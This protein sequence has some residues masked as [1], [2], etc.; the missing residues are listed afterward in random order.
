MKDFA[1]V[2][3]GIGGTSI[4]AYLSVKGYDVILFE[5]ESYLGGCSSTFEHRGYLY[6]TGATT[7]AGY[8]DGHGVKN[9]LDGIGI[10]PEIIKTDPAMSVV[11]NGICIHRYKDLDHFL[12]EIQKLHPH[13]KNR[14]FWKLV[15]FISTTFHEENGFYYKTSNPLSKIFSLFSYFPLLFKYRKYFFINAKKFIEIFFGTLSKEYLDFLDSQIL[16]VA[17]AKTADV[18]FFTAAL[19]LGYTFNTNYYIQGGFSSLFELISHKI[20]QVNRNSMVSLIERKGDHYVL[21]TDNGQIL[22]AKNLILNSTLYQSKFLFHDKEILQY[23][24]KFDTLQNTQSSFML[25]MTI[26]SDQKFDHHYQ[27]ISNEIIPL[28]I[29][30][31]LFVSFS[32]KTDELIAPKG[33]YSITASIHTDYLF[34]EEK[35]LYK[36]QKEELQKRLLAIICEN[37]HIHESEIVHYFSATP[38]SFQRYINRSQL[39]GNAMSMKNMLFMLPG[40]DSPIK[41]LYHVGDSVYPAQGWPGVI[42]GVEN[43]KK[44]LHV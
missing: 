1:V 38:K 34:W 25:Y 8:E 27:I 12:T 7:F 14:E 15:H 16:I 30:K 6:N 39:G 37:L 13:D 44:V 35:H 3:S 18:N 22:K 29:S 4:A 33:C 41:G 36:A 24:R 17:Q 43:L 19:A 9:F 32:D 42:M 20:K 23:Y 10:F 5:K 28:T 2:G 21:H 40:N 26:K 11:Q 31:A